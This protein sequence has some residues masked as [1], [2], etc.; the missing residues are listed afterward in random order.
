MQLWHLFDQP[1]QVRSGSVLVL[2][3]ILV[4]AAGSDSF[5]SGIED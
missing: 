2:R 4:T 1:A 3:F 5:V